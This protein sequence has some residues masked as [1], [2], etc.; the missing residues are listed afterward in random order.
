MAD[1]RNGSLSWTGGSNERWDWEVGRGQMVRDLLGHVKDLGLEPQGNGSH[2]I[3]LSRDCHHHT[4]SSWVRMKEG[5]NRGSRSQVGS[6]CSHRWE[7]WCSGGGEKWTEPRDA[8]E[9]KLMDRVTESIWGVRS[10]SSFWP[11]GIQADGPIP[12]LYPSHFPWSHTLWINKSDSIRINKWLQNT[13]FYMSSND[14]YWD[15]V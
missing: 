1:L 2:W 13:L 7:W 8:L 12:G 5:N 9:A 11:S 14:N 6:H 3:T 10:P 4:V 15:I